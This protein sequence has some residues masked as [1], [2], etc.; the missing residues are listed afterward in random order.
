MRVYVLLDGL[1]GTR[2]DPGLKSNFGTSLSLLATLA[3]EFTPERVEIRMYHT[4]KFRGLWKYIV[5]KRLN[6]GFG[7]QHIKLCAFDDEVIVTG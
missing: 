3:H 4:P 2:P 5:P 7:L 1:R 6:E